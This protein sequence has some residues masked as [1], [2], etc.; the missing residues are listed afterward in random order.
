MAHPTRR[1]PGG[2]A[3]LPLRVFKMPHGAAVATVLV[4]LA[5][6]TSAC[7]S[8]PS[9][10]SGDSPS[11][12]SSAAGSS[13]ST[14]GGQVDPAIA[15]TVPDKFRSAGA[16]KNIVFNNSPPATF[17]KD[18][19]EIGWAIELSEAIGGVLGLKMDTTVSG[20]SLRSY[21]GCRMA[22]MTGPSGRS[23][24]PQID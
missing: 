23:W 19:A 8:S 3:S 4:G 2:A 1:G 24:S 10:P 11:S 16:I 12:S 14:G 6:S 7:S 18:G 17:M 22:A 21:Q 15:A 5:V 9:A 20:T 13:A